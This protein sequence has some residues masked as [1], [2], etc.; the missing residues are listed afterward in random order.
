MKTTGDGGT[1]RH[2]ATKIRKTGRLTPY[3]ATV[4]LN[5]WTISS[6]NVLACF[7]CLVAV[8]EVVATLVAGAHQH[9]AEEIA[10]GIGVILIGYGV[11]LEERHSFRQ[12]M[13]GVRGSTEPWEEAMDDLCHGAGLLLLVFGLFA[14][15]AVTCLDLPDRIVHTAGIE[16]PV[17]AA[18]AVLIGAGI[19]VMVV[20]TL[21]LL[22]LKVPGDTRSRERLSAN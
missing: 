19:V 22:F 5:R 20:L 13:G 9:E 16:R 18:A 14:E 12:L 15:I 21:R 17:L 11:A 1:A 6:F 3:V 4:V 8:I 2:P 7:V 10:T